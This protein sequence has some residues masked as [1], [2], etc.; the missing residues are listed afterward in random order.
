MQNEYGKCCKCGEEIGPPF[1]RENDW[2]C[3]QCYDESHRGRRRPNPR[4]GNQRIPTHDERQQ[5]NKWQDEIDERLDRE[6][7][8]HKDT[9]Q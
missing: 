9:K 5:W 4:M 1:D 6:N 3:K 7:S 2:L 8:N